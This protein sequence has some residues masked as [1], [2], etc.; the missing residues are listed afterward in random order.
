[1]RLYHSRFLK[2]VAAPRGVIFAALLVWLLA[3]C[4]PRPAAPDL[5]SFQVLVDGKALPAQAPAGSSVDS[6][7]GAASV[8]LGPLDRVDPPAYTLLTGGESVRVVRVIESF[9]VVKVTIPF[10]HQTLRNESLPQG[11]ENEVYLQKGKNGTQ[12]ITYRR[13]SEDG[14][15]VSSSVIK[16]VQI[17][18]PVPEIVMIGI[19]APFYPV[20]I[21]GKLVYLRDGNA[22]LI[23]GTT[24]S[25]RAVVT[26]GDLDGRILSLSYDGVW[27][28]FT[29]R[30][31]EDGQINSLWAKD[32][33]SEEG[34]LVSLNATNVV[35]FADFAPL[36]NLKVVFSTV[37]PRP[38]APGWQANNDLNALNF[39]S[40]GWASR[41]KDKPVL[42][43]NSGGVYGWWGMT[44]AWAP[45]GGELA[46]ARPDGIGMLDYKTGLLTTTLEIVPYQ[47]RGEWA[48]V[49]GLSW[50]PDGNV[51]YTIDHVPQSDSL[52]PEN[53][54]LFDL[55]AVPVKGGPPVHLVSQ[56]GMFSYPLASPAQPLSS[57]EVAYQV[58]YLQAVFPN[59]SETSSYRLAVIDRDGSNRRLLFPEEGKPG[60]KPQ[61]DWGAW[62]PAPMPESGSFAVALV[63]QGNLW[64]VDSGTGAA[65]QVTGD[66]LTTRVLWR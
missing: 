19:Q 62:S 61:R 51:L 65:Q 56:A 21:P 49:P 50:G 23:E 36:S 39:S 18:E 6:A 38:A 60:L 57:G 25:R 47:T 14:V 27:L 48:W 32:I 3:A 22:W 16:S 8:K 12:E 45:G 41:W 1:M 20:A 66:G 10:E 34:A 40:S 54:Q 9:D 59:Q 52:S 55:L 2:P 11:K 53:S 28:L 64:L 24:G 46:Y 37:E 35:H 31:D 43:S 13:V 7:L 42:E 4:S 33:S 17:E 44:F 29:R 5:I 30:S 26:T 63:Y 15:E 58:A